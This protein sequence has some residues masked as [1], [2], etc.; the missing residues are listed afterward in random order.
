MG[1]PFLLGSYLIL[2]SAVDKVFVP[3]ALPYVPLGPVV[4]SV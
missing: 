2:K 3:G 1:L 4:F